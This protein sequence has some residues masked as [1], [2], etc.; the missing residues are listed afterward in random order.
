[1]APATKTKAEPK[2]APEPMTFAE[3]A[4]Q[5]LR[6]R[7]TKYRSLVTRHANGEQLGTADMEA[8]ADLMEQI[9][10]PQYTFE[11]DADAMRR[12]TLV[13][14]KV[15]AAAD[16]APEHKA[17]A[18]ELAAEI[19]VAKKK[20]A[21]M[22]EEHRI[23]VSKS[24]KHGT[25]AHTLNQLASEHPTVIADIDTAVRLRAEELDRRKRGALEVAGA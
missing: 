3:I 17:R 4:R 8:A 11:R 18:A 9:G 1:M 7:I 25:Y 14:A 21:A 19:A 10:L 22:Q 2:P 6:E 24:N 12:F 5:R 20:L 13:Q 15:Q 23:A 16:A